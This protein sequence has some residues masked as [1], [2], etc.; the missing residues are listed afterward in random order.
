M[1]RL[2]LA[3]VSLA[4]LAACQPATTE[5]TEEQKAEIAAEVDSIMNE[6]WAAY[7]TDFDYDRGMSFFSDEPETA[8]AND[9]EVYYTLSVIDETFRPFFADLQRQDVTPI[10]SRTI[11]LTSDVV[12][13]I[14]HN[15]VVVVDT[16]GNAGPEIRF[17]ETIVWV[18]RN[19]EWK[20]L[21][22]HGSTPPES[23]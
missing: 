16:A 23:M 11:V 13:T 21:L 17:A 10:D 2:A 5:L 7:S 20:V 19:G 22:G 18:K 3:A 6:W 14:R 8:W 12:Y 4:F 9:G 15:T 1:R